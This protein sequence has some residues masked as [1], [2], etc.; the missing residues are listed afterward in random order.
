MYQARQQLV[1]QKEAMVEYQK[2]KN[3]ME[4]EQKKPAESSVSQQ[5]TQTQA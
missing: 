4:E 2:M 5:Q 3:L 1:K